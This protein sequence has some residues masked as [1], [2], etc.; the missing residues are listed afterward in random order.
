MRCGSFVDIVA[1][2]TFAGKIAGGTDAKVNHA[3]R[4]GLGKGRGEVDRAACDRCVPFWHIQVERIRG[5]GAVTAWIAALR[6]HTIGV[7]VADRIEPGLCCTGHAGIADDDAIW[8]DMIEQRRQ[9]FLDQR[10]PVIHARKPTPFGHRLI[11]RVARGSR[12]KGFAVAAA[13]TL[14]A[15]LIEQCLR[16]RQQSELFDTADRALIGWIE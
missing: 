6:T 7:I 10:K 3:G 16:C 4:F 11:N 5:E 13:E 8:P 12:A 9:P 2:G 1:A 15:L 14:D